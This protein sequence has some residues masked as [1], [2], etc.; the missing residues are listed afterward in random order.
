MYIFNNPSWL[1]DSI[2][3]FKDIDDVTHDVF[4]SINSRL[5]FY[6]QEEP[7]VSI[8]I[9]AW[10]EELNILNCIY[11]L[12]KT[13]SKYPFEIIVADN[14]STDRT[15]EILS[16]LKVKYVLQSIQGCGPARQKGQELASGKYVLMADADCV[17]PSDWIN[18][19]IRSLEKKGVSCVY[20]RYSFI[21]NESLPRW[22]L[23]LYE[24]SRDVMTN[25]R[26]IKRPYLNALGMS[27]GYVREYGIA[28]GFVMRHIRGEDGRMAFDLM[29]YGKVVQIKNSKARVW[30]PPRTLV[31]EGDFFD[32]FKTRVLREL[33]RFFNY[34]SKPKPH[35]TKDSTNEPE[36][37]DYYKEK[38]KKKIGLN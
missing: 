37:K 18:I 29:N 22:Q 31:S 7:I 16:K 33:S 6:I 9:P 24:K 15:A 26:S 23:F 38:I 25:F 11:S 14:N 34:F 2:L 8:V 30:T 32:V 12:S 1:N 10:N 20:G 35:N 3:P 4:E 28:I 36:T 5:S 27:M 21:S 19:M 13:N 17:Y